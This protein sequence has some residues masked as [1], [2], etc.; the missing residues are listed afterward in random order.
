MFNDYF[1]LSIAVAKL[2]AVNEVLRDHVPTSVA[3]EIDSIARVVTTVVDHM[4]D[5]N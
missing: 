1:E 4:R 2:I 3:S 5:N